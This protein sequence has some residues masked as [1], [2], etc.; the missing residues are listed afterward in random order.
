[1]GIH[2]V[3]LIPNDGGFS[4]QWH[5]QQASDHDIDTPAAWDVETGDSAVIIAIVDT[6]V[7]W[8]HPDLGGQSP[9]TNGNIWTNWS[10]QNGTTGVDDDENGYIDDYRGWDW[11]QVS[12]AW[13]GEDATTPDNNPTDFNGHGTHCAG[14]ASAITNNGTGVLLIMRSKMGW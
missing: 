12:G 11:V 13:P 3:A 4:S 6:G 2:P 5:H 1:V 14:I 7:L 8:S 9:Y 10:E